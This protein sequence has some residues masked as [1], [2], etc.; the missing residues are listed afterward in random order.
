[1]PFRD[2][3]MDPLTRQTF[4]RSIESLAEE[5]RGIYSLETIERYVDESIDRLS[6]APL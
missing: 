2:Q 5:F 4:T 6:G 1:M 3:P